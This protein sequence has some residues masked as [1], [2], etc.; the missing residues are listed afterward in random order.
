MAIGIGNAAWSCGIYAISFT[1]RMFRY[2]QRSP[3]I[4]PD[5]PWETERTLEEEIGREP[6]LTKP[7]GTRSQVAINVSPSDDDPPDIKARL[8]PDLF[9]VTFFLLG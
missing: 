7:V 5:Q 2:F 3:I 4:I 9:P 8:P 1:I 6:L